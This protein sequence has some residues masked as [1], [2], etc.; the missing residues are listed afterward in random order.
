MV[1]D[2]RRIL[3]LAVVVTMALPMTG[4]CVSQTATNAASDRQAAIAAEQQGNYVEAEI[5]WRAFSKTHPSNAEAFAHLGFLVAKQEHYSQAVPLYRKAFALDPTMPGLRLNLGL[6]LFK[7]G[8]MKDAIQ[9]LTP[10]LKESPASSPEAQRLDV[11]IGMSHYGLGEY[12]AAIP[13]FKEA[14]ARDPQSL[15]LR[16]ALAQSCLASKQFPCVLDVYRE[17]LALNAESAEADMLAGEA[18]DEMRDHAGAIREF[19][20]AA[21]ADPKMPNVHFALGYVLWT[22]NQIEEAAKEF[23]AELA[24]TPDHPQALVYLADVDIKLSDT[25]GALTLLEKAT[26]LDPRIALGHLDLGIVYAD[27]GRRTEALREMK[28]AEEQAPNDQTVHWHL[29]RYYK[30]AGKAT[31]AKA[32]FD[33]TRSLHKASDETVFKKL[34]E[35]QAKGQPAVQA[36]SVPANNELQR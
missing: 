19:Q 31:E 13:Y 14:T 6:S 10:L 11:L 9:T 4:T 8:D 21:K 12:A 28:I 34:N 5:A 17:I 22:Q 24:N 35:A 26:R 16:L 36:Q 15:W 18:L 1:I 25:N 3:Q 2:V 32:E 20:A 30:E 27:L 33:K 23:S 7:S 29:A